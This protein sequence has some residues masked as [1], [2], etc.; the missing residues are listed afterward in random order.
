MRK[1]LCDIFSFLLDLFKQIIN[2][3]AETLIAIGSAVVDV[4]SEV[5]DGLNN[6]FFSSPLGLILLGVG[7][8]WAI[9]VITKE[10]DVE[11]ERIRASNEVNV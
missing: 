7:A 1:F 6:M 11:A 10:T 9:S 4:L 2:V 8:F 3:V 5:V